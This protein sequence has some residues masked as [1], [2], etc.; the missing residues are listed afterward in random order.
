[1]PL[2]G[3]A[4]PGLVTANKVT[5]LLIADLTFINSPNHNLELYA[6]PF[7]VVNVTILAPP[8]TGVDPSMLALAQ[9]FLAP[10]R[11]GSFGESL[12]NAAGSYATAQ[13][14]DEQRI[15]D[16]AKMRYELARQGLGD[17][18]TA[19]TMGLNVA[20]KLTPKLTAVQ[21]QVQAV[22]ASAAT[23]LEQTAAELDAVH[24][25]QVERARQKRRVTIADPPQRDEATTASALPRGSKAD[26]VDVAARRH[27][28]EC[29]LDG[30]GDGGCD[31]HAA[32]A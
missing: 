25:R 4:R 31:R 26:E 10:T 23:K 2:A 22:A 3:C 19:A 15:R 14:A 7:E 13:A 11:T 20:S 16:L 30:C 1:V 32:P 17:E 28:L 12:G 21:Q 9:G 27:L 24:T 6:S 8:S 5:D 29:G 18:Q